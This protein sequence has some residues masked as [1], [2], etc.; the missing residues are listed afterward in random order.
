MLYSAFSQSG[1]QAV[2]LIAYLLELRF[3][4][5][6]L[7]HSL[8]LVLLSCKVSQLCF[9]CIAILEL[10]ILEGRIHSFLLLSASSRHE[11]EEE[12]LNLEYERSLSLC[13]TMTGSDIR[14]SL[15]VVLQQPL[16]RCLAKARLQ[17]K[18]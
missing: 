16:N 8:L 3:C 11:D 1:A 10:A 14:N 7:L 17:S 4:V 13:E 2:T 6:D 15:T 5:S 12:G 9:V 18:P